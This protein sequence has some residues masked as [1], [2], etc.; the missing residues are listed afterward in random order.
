[1][2]FRSPRE[3]VDIAAQLIRIFCIMGVRGVFATH[4]NE[5]AY[6]ARELRSEPD[7]RTKPESF[8]VSVNPETGERLYKVVKGLP[9]ESSFAASVF[10]KY[11]LDIPALE[12]KAS[13]MFM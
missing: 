3:C 12:K 5:L 7:I 4:L 8:V 11:G 9:T 6:K 2:L 10:A 13:K 1:M